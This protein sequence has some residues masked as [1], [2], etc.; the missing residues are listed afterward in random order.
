MR[1]YLGKMC[2]QRPAL[3]V[4]AEEYDDGDWP[5]AKLFKGLKAL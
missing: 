4:Y 1:K 3:T 5:M 2:V